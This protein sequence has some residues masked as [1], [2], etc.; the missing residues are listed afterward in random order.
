MK[1]LLYIPSGKYVEFHVEDTTSNKTTWSLQ[2]FY[3]W[4]SYNPGYGR[5]YSC[6]KAIVDSFRTG[7]WNQ[8]IYKRAEIDN[9]QPILSSEFEIVEDRN[10]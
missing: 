9:D 8:N 3:E 4:R 1:Q 7:E 10:G 2:E 6:Y 5:M